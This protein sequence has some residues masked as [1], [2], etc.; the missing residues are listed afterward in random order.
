MPIGS[1]PKPPLESRQQLIDDI[2]RVQIDPDRLISILLANF[3]NIDL[4]GIRDQLRK[5]ATK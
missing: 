3:T 4:V 2:N 1:R 5:E